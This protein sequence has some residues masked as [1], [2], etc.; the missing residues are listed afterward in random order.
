MQK[1][2]E[3]GEHIG[4]VL[5]DGSARYFSDP[6]DA[7]ALQAAGATKDVPAPERAALPA[8]HAL[9]LHTLAPSPTN[10]R[11][12]FAEADLADLAASIREQG[13]MQPI[14]VR[15]W[16]D[17]YPTPEGRDERPLYEIV[18]GER[19]YR[20]S[21]LA[22][23]ADIP[24]LVR[25][26]NTRQVLEA[27]IVENLQ[28]RDVSELEE[29][30][31]Y[32]LMMR[33]HGYSADELAEKVGKSKAY[34][35]ARLKLTALC[36]FA[37]EAYRTGKLDASRALLIARIP[38]ATLQT[39]AVKEITEDRWDG[40]MTYRA[41]ARHVQ[42]NYML[43]LKDAPFDTGDA[44]L[45]VV[46]GPCTKCPDNTANARELFP[47][48]D[49][50]V[51][52]NPQCFAD[53]KTNHVQKQAETHEAMGRKI[54]TGKAA[55][56]IAPSGIYG[57]T[58]GDYVLLDEKDYY[59]GEYITARKAIKGQD[60]AEVMIEDVRR[61]R[62]VPAIAKKDLA[63]ALKAA[64]LPTR[65]SSR[66]PQEIARDRARK[67][68]QAYR[69]ELFDRHRT[70]VSIDLS[71]QHFPR[72]QPPDMRLIARQFWAHKGSDAQKRLGRMYVPEA[73]ERDDAAPSWA[74]EDHLRARRLTT[75][76]DGFSQPEL[77]MFLF[78]LALVGTLDVPAYMDDVST[79][80]P[81]LDAVRRAGLDPEAI[82]ADLTEAKAGKGKASKPA[83]TPKQAA[84]AAD[85]SAREKTRAELAAKGIKYCH[86]ENSLITWSGRGRKPTW[87]DAWIK[88]GGT[89]EELSTANQ[90][91]P[92]ADDT[93]TTKA[94][95]KGKGKAAA[96]AKTTKAK[97]R[98][99]GRASPAERKEKTSSSSDADAP[100]ERCTKTM[101]MIEATF[102]ELKASRGGQEAQ[103]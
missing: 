18:A 103:A 98:S 99:S 84:P 11:K 1:I 44:F 59:G 90:A 101:D 12:T 13:V 17:E 23:L 39:K 64:G 93:P 33:E 62:L 26:L 54:I 77:I 92:A 82:R 27:Q 22:G 38:G 14:V 94:S 25:A 95:P 97:T 68:E 87:V 83:P 86:P 50:D 56:K 78:D 24:A 69:K 80:A 52:T 96:A 31:G 6:T 16:P 73:P 36:E 72:L 35:Y 63:E 88:N 4:W 85:D 102:P 15:L 2:I 70:A 61:G 100:I 42:Q 34:I 40:P 55:E 45:L 66:S 67:D 46:R 53:K 74:D 28:R 89:L 71:A 10:P 21:L 76:I 8:L 57:N 47:D 9:A 51:C 91:A 48:V 60:I 49:A 30:E 20:A 3:N 81:L 58:A 65:S 79:P 5:D 43:K 75:M 7:E 41:A 29:A 32:D 19:R 37:R